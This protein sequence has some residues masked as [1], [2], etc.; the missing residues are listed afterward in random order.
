M[1]ICFFEFDT[2]LFATYIF[3][4]NACIFDSGYVLVSE[5]V[6][7][8]FVNSGSSLQEINNIIGDLT[9]IE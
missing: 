6:N 5:L 7:V 9:A 1:E 4:H 8:E 2:T 3:E